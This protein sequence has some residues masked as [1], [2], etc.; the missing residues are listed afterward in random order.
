M[1]H[2]DL[3][4][5]HHEGFSDAARNAAPHVMAILR[6]HGIDR[7]LIVDLGCGSGILSAELLAHGYDVLGIDLSPSMIAL[8]RQHAPRATFVAGSLHDVDLPPCAAITAIGEPFTYSDDVALRRTFARCADALPPGGMLLF[9][10]IEH[11]DGE[12]MQYRSWRAAG[13]DWLLAVDVAEEG[14]RIMRTMWTY[15]ADGELYRRS[16]EV[17]EAWTFTRDELAAWL[18]ESGFDVELGGWELPP[19]RV[20]VQARKR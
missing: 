1:Y 4:W 8:A 17:H 18:D 20:A 3:A 11:V 9:D 12:A 6:A 10:V 7:G 14:R 13:D 5:I 16:S 19:R 2:G 15:R